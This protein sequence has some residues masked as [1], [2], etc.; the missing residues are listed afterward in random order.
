MSK[1]TDAIYKCF[2]NL[3]D[4]QSRLDNYSQSFNKICDDE[5]AI[6]ELDDIKFN[7]QQE[8][9]TL[10]FWFDSLYKYNGKSTSIMKKNASAENGKKG[11]RPPK[12][13][14][15]KKRRIIQLEEEIIPDIEHKIVMADSNEELANLENQKTE[16]ENEL[17][18]CKDCVNKWI[19]SKNS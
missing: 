5:S 1:K 12:E 4:L 10:R 19:I 16:Y 18:V 17:S 2:H 3:E 15:I 9:K 8:L 7:F 6:R 14:S 13:I 11:G